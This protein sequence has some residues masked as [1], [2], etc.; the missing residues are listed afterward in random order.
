MNKH[1]ALAI[2]C[3][4]LAPHF[5][6]AADEWVQIGAESE[7]S[8]AYVEIER[9]TAIRHGALAQALIRYV[10]REP[11]P[12]PFKQGSTYRLAI[13]LTEFDCE[14]NTAREVRVTRYADLTDRRP[15]DDSPP[16]TP[17]TRVL[18]KTVNARAMAIAC[19]A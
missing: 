8:T 16:Q 5:A 17:I 4:S 11:V 18:P 3:L 15:V 2:L 6:A 7:A 10:W 1:L 14:R 12:V 19:K 9:T 13:V